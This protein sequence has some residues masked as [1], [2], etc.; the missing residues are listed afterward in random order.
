P[1]MGGTA[2]RQWIS[3]ALLRKRKRRGAER[4]AEIFRADLAQR[5]AIDGDVVVP[6]QLGVALVLLLDLALA[7]QALAYGR[8]DVREGG[9]VP[10]FTSGESDDVGTALAFDL[11]HAAYLIDREQRVDHRRLELKDSGS[12]D[13]E[14]GVAARAARC[15][16]LRMGA[17]QC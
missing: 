4:G 1:R 6:A 2:R 17:D 3:S 10:S 16:I 7:G 8:L 11:N 12:L 13:D 14:A 15:G 9:G 5:L